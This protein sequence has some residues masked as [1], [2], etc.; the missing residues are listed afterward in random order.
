[1]NTQYVSLIVFFLAIASLQAQQ[2]TSLYDLLPVANQVA[3]WSPEEEPQ[4]AVGD[5]LYLLINGGAVIYQEYGFKQAVYCTYLNKEE[6]AINCEIYQ[7]SDPKASF[8]IYSFKTRSDGQP[9]DLGCSGWLGDYYLNFWSGNYQVTVVGLSAEPSVIEAVQQ[10]ASVIAKQLKCQTV[11]PDLTSLMPADGLLPNGIVYLRGPVS[12][13]NQYMFDRKDVFAIKDG[14]A[15]RYKD[16]LVFIFQYTSHEEARK[17]YQNSWNLF[18]S[19]DVYTD[20]V[21][22]KDRYMM[23][24]RKQQ[25]II[26]IRIR[27]LIVV[28]VSRGSVPLSDE[29]LKLIR[30]NI[31]LEEIDE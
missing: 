6:Q 11:F 14:V 10:I 12:L 5:D 20:A 18:S 31:N 13:R 26:V 15:G 7:M 22:E 1:M 21:I 9:A 19:G 17:I 16:Q 8:G 4:V 24:D 27:G 28:L 30:K 23:Q 25:S 29:V 3:G 2:L